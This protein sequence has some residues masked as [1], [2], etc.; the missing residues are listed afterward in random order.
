LL[1]SKDDPEMKLG[2]HRKVITL[3]SFMGSIIQYSR[4]DDIQ[5]DLD[6]GFRELYPN[7]DNS[8]T[9]A[10]IRD[11]KSSMLRVGCLQEMEYSSIAMS[12]VYFERLVLKGTLSLI[13]CL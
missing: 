9:L 12:Y 1:D 10:M 11:M 5:R 8:L 6:I 2:K 13:Q 7:I 4:P 3:P